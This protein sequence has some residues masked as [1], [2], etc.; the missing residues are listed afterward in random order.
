MDSYLI[1]EM[2][3]AN[4]ELVDAGNE[5]WPGGTHHELR[6]IGIEIDQITDEV[7]A[8]TPQ[9]DEA[10]LPGMGQ[11][12]AVSPRAATDGNEGSS[13]VPSG[14]GRLRRVDLRGGISAGQR[15]NSLVVICGQGR[16][17]TADL[18]LFRRSSLAAQGSRRS[19]SARG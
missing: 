19:V 17:R 4:P 9:G 11:G 12:V 14:H 10:E 13:A 18:P 7:T 15:R 1:Y 3:A 16:G 5:P 2:A 8:R 6:S